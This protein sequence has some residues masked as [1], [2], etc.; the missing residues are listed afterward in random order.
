MRN[1]QSK[2]LLKEA[3]TLI[4]RLL[5]LLVRTMGDRRISLSQ[6]IMLLGTILYVLSPLDL[7]P[8]FIPFTGQ[9]DDILLLAMVILTIMQQ[10]GQSVFRDGWKEQQNLSDLA[11]RIS[12]LA[13]SFLPSSI[14]ERIVK[15]SGY[16]DDV[17]DVKYYVHED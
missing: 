1:Q 14:Y 13:S 4:P 5:R 17:I 11:H 9:V 12:K 3:I 6:K 16:R 8:D 7:M 15:R 10:A 2:T